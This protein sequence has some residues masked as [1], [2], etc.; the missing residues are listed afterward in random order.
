MPRCKN[1]RLNSSLG[2]LNHVPSTALKPTPWP[3]NIGSIYRTR[4]HPS[5]ILSRH[6][7]RLSW[8]E[9]ASQ[10]SP[11][12]S[13]AITA[14]MRKLIDTAN[15][16]L[17]EHPKQT[18]DPA[19]P[20]EISVAPSSDRPPVD[21]QRAARPRRFGVGWPVH[22]VL[23]RQYSCPSAITLAS[24]HESL[25]ICATKPDVRHHEPTIRSVTSSRYRRRSSHGKRRS[26]CFPAIPARLIAPAARRTGA[27]NLAQVPRWN[28]CR[29]PSP[30]VHLRD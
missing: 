1:R 28:N 4:A 21:R 15:A 10:G 17:P 12:A 16:C 5:T 22:D 29:L 24:Q 11:R 30:A 9:A 18:Q 13:M 6:I 19:L 26:L 23:D 3:L 7:P 8:P 14:V 2:A 25:T 27:H 20:K